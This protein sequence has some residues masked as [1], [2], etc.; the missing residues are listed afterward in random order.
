VLVVDNTSAGL[1]G[2]ITR[3][4]SS[5]A[6]VAAIATLAAGDGSNNANSTP[7]DD[8]GNGDIDITVRSTWT[9]T[10]EDLLRG[11]YSANVVVTVAAN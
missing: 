4:G 2:I 3:T 8:N 9:S 5:A 7:T 10:G 1:D 6:A 11:T